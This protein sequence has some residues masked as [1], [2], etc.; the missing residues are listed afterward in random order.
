[1][2]THYYEVGGKLYPPY[3]HTYIQANTISSNLTID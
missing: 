3:F 2:S 1:L